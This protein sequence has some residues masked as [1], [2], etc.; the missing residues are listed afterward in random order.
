MRNEREI[1][2]LMLKRIK[3]KDKYCHGLCRASYSLMALQKIT[4]DEFI[5][6]REYLSENRNG[7]VAK[8]SCAAFWWDTG[9]KKP[10]VKWLKKHIKLLKQ[11]P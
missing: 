2:K 8:N 9:E 7:L 6:I 3:R 4:Y 10:R 1:L 11:K 5:T